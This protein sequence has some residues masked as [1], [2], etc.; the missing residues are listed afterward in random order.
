[1]KRRLC[2]KKEYIHHFKALNFQH[3]ASIIILLCL[4]EN[5]RRISYYVPAFR[6]ES[7][8]IPLQRTYVYL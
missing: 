3:I 2:D 6:A 5:N 8:L 4:V 7:L 1:M